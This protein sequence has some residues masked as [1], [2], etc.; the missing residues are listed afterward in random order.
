MS[1]LANMRQIEK[2]WLT[3]SPIFEVSGKRRDLVSSADKFAEDS[4]ASTSS[5]GQESDFH[6]A[7]SS[8]SFFGKEFDETGGDGGGIPARQ[9]VARTRYRHRVDFWDPLLQ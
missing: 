7:H 4:T 9:V 5:G 8:K 6:N 2:S 3:R 1:D